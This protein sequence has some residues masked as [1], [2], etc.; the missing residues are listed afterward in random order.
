MSANRFAAA[1]PAA[2]ATAARR[3]GAGRN[4]RPSGVLTTPRSRF[5]SLSPWGMGTNPAFVDSLQAAHYLS[6]A[7]YHPGHP[8]S[9]AAPV[10]LVA[11]AP[12]AGSYAVVRDIQIESAF[13]HGAVRPREKDFRL[14]K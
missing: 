4:S 13:I 9:S 6:D 5:A 3:D 12:R 1:A 11:I 14:I 10:G 2:P 8:G 7:H